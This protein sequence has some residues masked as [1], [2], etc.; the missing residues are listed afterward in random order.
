MY[1]ENDPKR[2]LI[3]SGK[4]F[5]TV[6]E[7]AHHVAKSSGNKSIKL[8]LSAEDDMGKKSRVYDYLSF[9]GKKLSQF[10]NSHG[11]YEDYVKTNVVPL[12]KIIGLTGEYE[13]V[14]DEYNGLWQNKVY[15]YHFDP[16]NKK[17]KQADILEDAKLSVEPPLFDDVDIPF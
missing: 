13:N 10:L 2:F 6:V 17:P 1:D 15:F 12:D 7:A 4:C 11:L 14:H 5:Y 16:K 3:K 9:T 8:I